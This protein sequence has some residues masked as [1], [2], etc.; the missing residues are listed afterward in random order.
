VVEKKYQKRKL[1]EQKNDLKNAQG[2]HLRYR[3]KP[4]YQEE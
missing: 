2:I 4:R 3:R 1:F